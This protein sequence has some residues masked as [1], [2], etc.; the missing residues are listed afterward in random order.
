MVLSR[1]DGN[2][3]S[4]KTDDIKDI[5]T[6]LE[7]NAKQEIDDL[8]FLDKLVI[9][10]DSRLKGYFDVMMMFASIF[11]VFTNAYYSAFGEP[12]SFY[13]SIADTII[14]TQFFLDMIFNMC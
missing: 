7:N 14:E 8:A 13:L 2:R 11:N 3:D 10:K 1:A 4:V 12:T 9:S 5:S 6:E